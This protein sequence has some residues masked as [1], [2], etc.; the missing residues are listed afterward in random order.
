MIVRL[1]TLAFPLAVLFV[2]RARADE[3]WVGQKVMNTKPK[4]QLSE[5]INDKVVRFDLTGSLLPVLQ[6]R[7]GRLRVRDYL[8]KEGW[9]EKADFVLVSDAPAFFTQLIRKDPKNVW[10]WTM[11]GNAWSAKNADNAI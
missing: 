5:R 1:L 8:G 3:S 7:D 6:D 2:P 11:R 9:A 10:A 4:V